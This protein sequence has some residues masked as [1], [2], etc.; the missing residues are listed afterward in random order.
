ME[1]LCEAGQRPR[2]LMVQI[3]P[4]GLTFRQRPG[5]S[6][7]VKR[8]L[9]VQAE[10]LRSAQ[11]GRELCT[12]AS[13]ITTGQKGMHAG[14]AVTSLLLSIWYHHRCTRETQTLRLREQEAFTPGE[15]SA[16]LTRLLA[17]SWKMH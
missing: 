10:G 9:L 12:P 13:V 1:W 16:F 15:L 7:G 5:S 6:L 11:T 17:P 14:L 8:L 4:D 3:R 2:I